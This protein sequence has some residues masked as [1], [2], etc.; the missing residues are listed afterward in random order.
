MM[1]HQLAK[2]VS[3]ATIVGLYLTAIFNIGYFY[4]IGYHFIGVIDISNVVYT[5][6]LIV[7]F[8]IIFLTLVGLLVAGCVALYEQSLF[9]SQTARKVLGSLLALVLLALLVLLL[10]LI[11][12]E[13]YPA[14]AHVS[15]TGLISP[16][17]GIALGIAAYV[18][19]KKDGSSFPDWRL[20]WASFILVSIGMIVIGG[21]I[22]KQQVSSD[23][24][25]YDIISKTGTFSDVRI[26]RSSSSGFIFSQLGRVMF[27]PMG[28]V[29]LVSATGS[30]LK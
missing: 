15:A 19:W 21:L 12:P 26:V 4:V 3:I 5:F 22:A 1:L 30:E 23:V 9:W 27:V 20:I 18:K 14:E 28:E 13:M 17:V 16:L 10:W 2:A 24:V 29:R 11:A 25:Q 7:L 8:L 6:G